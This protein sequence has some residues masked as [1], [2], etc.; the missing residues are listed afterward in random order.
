MRRGRGT[1]PRAVVTAGG[2]AEPIDDVRVVTNRSRGRLGA[3]IAGALADRGVAV[4]LLASRS[5]ASHPEWIDPRVEVVSF[6]SF[7]DLE[8]QLDAAIAEPPDLVFMAAAVS[9][10]TPV[11]SAGKLSSDAERLVVEMRRNPKLL[12]GLRKRCGVETFLVGF[13]LLSGVERA[14]LRRVG[15]EQVKRCR[16]NLCLAN[17]LA[18][19]SGAEHPALML[20]AEGGAIPIAG[21]KAA[22]A[23][24]L[25]DFALARRAVSWSRSIEDRSIAGDDDAADRA[26]ALLRFAQ[27]AHLLVDSDGNASAR[28]PR[29]LAITPRQVDKSTTE[30][31]VFAE[32]DPAAR[33]V[34]YRGAGKPSIDTAVHAWLYRE[35]PEL[36]AICHFHDALAI[37]AVETRFPWPCGTV[38]E[39]IEIHAG[40]GRAAAAGQWRGGDVLI[41]LVDHGYLLGLTAAGAAAIADRWERIREQHLGHLARLGDA[42]PGVERFVPVF[43]GADIVG[44]LGHA[45]LR[46]SDYVTLFVSPDRRGESLGDELVAEISGRRMVVA[47]HDL[48]EVREFYTARGFKVVRRVGA[49]VVLEPPSLRDDLREAGSVCLFDPMSRQVMIGRRMTEPWRGYWAFPGG[50]CEGDETRLEAAVREL[51]EETGVEAPGEP[52][53][54]VVVSVGSGDGERAYAVESF[55]FACFS[56]PEPRPS[57]ELE[58][59]WCALDEALALRP[60]AAGTRR[61]LRALERSL[62]GGRWRS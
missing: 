5:L 25:V 62:R 27:A 24:R 55:V 33:V 35:H 54:S 23:A 50:G 34:R 10:Y 4:T 9:D 17:D 30:E 26:A 43:S 60:M 21:D 40:L 3:A 20:T 39:A 2:T 51:A 45:H 47:A 1:K 57:A 59:R 16:L 12:A 53:R 19:L 58:A 56:R 52:M 42:G 29:G 49:L 31:L 7:A 8:R 37:G 41:R 11:A 61:V 36:A 22:V 46:G 44:S 48:C 38:E 32:V 13:K 28:S 6:E 18:E 15:L 14:E